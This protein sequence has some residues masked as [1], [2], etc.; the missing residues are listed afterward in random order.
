MYALGRHNE[1]LACPEAYG[2]SINHIVTLP[3]L[4]EGHLN[5]VMKMGSKPAKCT[6]PVGCLQEPSISSRVKSERF[7]HLAL[8]QPCLNAAVALTCIGGR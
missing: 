3:M 8:A 1:E 2:D 7:G 4:Q 5:F 6:K